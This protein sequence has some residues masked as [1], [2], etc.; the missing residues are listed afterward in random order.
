MYTSLTLSTGVF[1]L[2][3]KG[4]I[5][6]NTVAGLDE[7]PLCN[8]DSLS[9]PLLSPKTLACKRVFSLT[10]LDADDDGFFLNSLLPNESGFLF[11]FIAF[12]LISALLLLRK[13]S[14]FFMFFE[15]FLV[16][17]AFL[18]F[19][20]RFLVVKEGNGFNNLASAFD[21]GGRSDQS[22]FFFCVGF[23]LG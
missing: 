14:F 6:D 8:L 10:R 1:G 12:L 3:G 17:E 13:G 20:T 11:S 19:I 21:K 5:G 18:S 9:L 15:I 4:L 16:R 23:G 22:G 7:S 2:G